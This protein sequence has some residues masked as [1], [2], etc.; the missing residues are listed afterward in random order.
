M[1]VR[2]SL[3]PILSILALVACTDSDDTG[4]G[5]DG[6][7]GGTT[8]G[9]GGDALITI[10]G[11]AVDFATRAFAHEGLCIHAADPTAA[12]TGGDF[13]VLVSGTVGADG[14]FSLADVPT[15]STVGLMLLIADCAKE[16][17]VMPS[18][19][20]IAAEDYQDLANGASLSDRIAYS[21]DVPTASG[22]DMSLAAVGSANTV[23]VDGALVGTVIDSAGAPIGGATVTGEGSGATAYY[24]DGDIA[25]GL[26][27][28]AGAPN[29]STSVATGGLFC[30]PA[31]PVWSYIAE[32][33]GN[34]TF[35][36]LLAGSQPGYILF[37]RF[38]AD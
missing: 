16:G 8:D 9:G 6:G 13:E 33:G 4:G 21:V 23:T 12:V 38:I 32:D 17:T 7:D 1:H 2:P 29:T 20:G 25:D 37:V 19:T 22:M 34:H 10:S 15:T 3:L 35:E 24:F 5:D 31:A 30:I 26:F 27:S 18:A 11:T 14:S 36:P 28:T